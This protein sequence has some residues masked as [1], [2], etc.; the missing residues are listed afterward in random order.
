MVERD[1]QDERLG[2]LVREWVEERDAE[3]PGPV[4]VP[5]L[6]G[7]LRLRLRLRRLW[8]WAR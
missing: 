2:V 4:P 6:F 7:R 1:R 5:T 8:R 3:V